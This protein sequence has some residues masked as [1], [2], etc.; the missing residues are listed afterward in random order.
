MQN[1]LKIVGKLTLNFK[2]SADI[3]REHLRWYYY[4]RNVCVLQY[5]NMSILAV[6]F[7]YCALFSLNTVEGQRVADPFVPVRRAQLQARVL[8]VLIGRM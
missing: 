6:L 3:C 5:L 2:S 7:K 8:T 4:K 1:A